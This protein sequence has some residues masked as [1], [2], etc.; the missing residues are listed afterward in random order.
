MQVSGKVLPGRSIDMANNLPLFF[1]PVLTRRSIFGS[2]NLRA[3]MVSVALEQF[4]TRI[5]L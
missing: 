1:L 4:L 2:A 5:G 3:Y